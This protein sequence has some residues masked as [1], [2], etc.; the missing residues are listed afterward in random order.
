MYNIAIEVNVLSIIMLII[1]FFSLRKGNQ[2]RDKTTKALLIVLWLT[3]LILTTDVFRILFNGRPSSIDRF[4]LTSSTA[5]YY[6]MI[7]V[8]IVGWCHYIVMYMLKKKS[9]TK[10]TLVFFGF[11]V[12]LNSLLAILSIRGGYLFVI[13]ANNNYMRG[14]W[15]L[16]TAVMTFF[17]VFTSTV[18]ITY[19]QKEINRKDFIP[20]LSFGLPVTVAGLMQTFNPDATV[21]APS[22]AISIL[23]IFIHVQS[24]IL[25]TDFLTG[26]ANRR[27][28]E[29]HLET[30][31]KKCC[32]DLELGGIVI[33]IDDF[34]KVNDNHGHSIGDEVLTKV[35]EILKKSVRESDFVA[36]L[37]GD[38]FSI[39]VLYKEKDTLEEIVDRINRNVEI[40]NK[41]SKLDCKIKLS[42]GFGVY[43]KKANYSIEHFF[44]HLDEKMY[45]EKVANKKKSRA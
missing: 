20:L 33:D 10:I 7:P 34:K 25:S 22:M 14:E 26:L 31:E 39:A 41:E 44:I 16:V 18:Y 13:D 5:I 9:Y 40:Y 37:G 28:Y 32:K 30:L 15:F 24:R 35:G 27:D 8:I 19:Y 4:L 2:H 36:R 17:V 29:N 42:I 23:I 1:V 11:L 3:L 21:I 12:A 38:E 45:K 43:Q 6:S